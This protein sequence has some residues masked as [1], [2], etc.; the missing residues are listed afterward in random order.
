MACL[1]ISSSKLRLSLVVAAVYFFG[2]LSLVLLD[3]AVG[4][5][6]DELCGTVVLLE[7]EQPCLGVYGLEVQDVVDVGS[8]ESIDALCV[9][10]N[11]ADALLFAGEL[12][13]D[14]LLCVVGVL[15][16]VDEYIGE[17]LCILHPDIFLVA[18]EKEGVEQQVV[19]VHGVGLSASLL[20]GDEDVGNLG[21]VA[22]AVIGSGTSVGCI[23]LGRDELVFCSADAVVYG[24]R[25]VYLVVEPSFLDDALQQ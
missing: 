15:I 24:C 13:H 10:A 23:S 2:Y 11:D 25:L 4:G 20:V 9:V 5:L 14:A 19:E 22:F 3:E 16:L 12:Q 1:R 17:V 7:F 18:E 6:H 8:A 21:H